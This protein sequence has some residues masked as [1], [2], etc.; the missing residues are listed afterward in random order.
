M[1]LEQTFATCRGNLDATDN[2]GYR[3]PVRESATPVGSRRPYGGYFDEVVDRLSATLY[4]GGVAFAD[5]VGK[6]LVSGGQLTLDVIRR[7]LVVV[8]GVLRDDPRLRFELCLGVSCVQ[9]PADVGLL[10]HAVYQLM[11]I[12]HNRRLRLEVAVPHTDPYV[13]S[14]F[15]VYPTTGRHEREVYDSFG[16]V[17]GGHPSLTRSELDDERTAARPCAGDRRGPVNGADTT[18]TKRKAS[19]GPG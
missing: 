11:S 2:S 6:T 19:G 18:W 12:T 3:R 13:P 15:S 9:H 7:Y 4:D 5:A 1:G 8:A 16:I 10:L 14:L 17:F